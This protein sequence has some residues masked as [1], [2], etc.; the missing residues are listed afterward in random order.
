MDHVDSQTSTRLLIVDANPGARAFLQETLESE[1]FE[2]SVV[3]YGSHALELLRKEK[4]DMAL[5]DL[6]LPDL[7]GYELCAQTKQQYPGLVTIIMSESVSGAEKDLHHESVDGWLAK[8]LNSGELMQVVNRYTRS[9]ESSVRAPVAAPVSAID[10][11]K[12]RFFHEVAHQLKTPIA[13]LKEFAHLFKEGFGGDLT[14]KQGQYL[15]AID[16]N[17]DRLLYLV[18]HIDQLSRVEMGSWSIRLDQVNPATVVKKVA[19]SWRPLLEKGG[20]KLVE[21]V[22][23]GLPKIEADIL[24]LEQVLFNMVDNARKYGPSGS[25]II[26][27]CA[28][29]GDDHVCIEVEDQGVS[30]PEEEREAVF[31]PFSRLPEHQSSPG[32]GLGLTVARDLVQR[33]GGELRLESG[34]ETGNRFCL[35]IR[36]AGTAD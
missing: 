35:Q 16:Q 33:M 12:N 7:S 11:E 13:V 30:I 19:D 18:D 14:E 23:E 17:I 31:Q 9:F 6:A 1:G 5:V 3:P 36:V 22:T 28:R 26:L 2:V 21:E 10:E 24:A 15:E 29:S 25:T 20:F 4:Y 34:I 27:R 8:P 32:L